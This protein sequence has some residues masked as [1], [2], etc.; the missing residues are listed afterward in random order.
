MNGAHSPCAEQNLGLPFK[1]PSYQNHDVDHASMSHTRCLGWVPPHSSS[2]S[3]PVTLEAESKHHTWV[4]LPNQLEPNKMHTHP[5]KSSSQQISH[6]PGNR[7]LSTY[8]TGTQLGQHWST[9]GCKSGDHGRMADGRGLF[10][11]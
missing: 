5:S 1:E 8:L 6:Q 2:S 4:F 3:Y 9:L 7:S 10:S 11:E